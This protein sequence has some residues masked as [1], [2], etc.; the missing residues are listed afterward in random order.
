LASRFL[1][2]EHRIDDAAN[3]Y[4]LLPLAAVAR[5]ARHL[6]CSDCSNTPEAD[7]GDH[8]LKAAS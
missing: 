6:A 7:L 3:L 8:A 5:K 4:E 2:D 1:V